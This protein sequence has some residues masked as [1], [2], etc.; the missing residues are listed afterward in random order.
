MTNM[1]SISYIIWAIICSVA[2][3]EGKAFLAKKKK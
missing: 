1:I 3:F 2:A